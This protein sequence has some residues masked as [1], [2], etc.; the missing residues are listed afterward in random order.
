MGKFNHPKF[1]RFFCANLGF[2]TPNFIKILGE[3]SGICRE[4]VKR[5]DTIVESCNVTKIIEIMCMYVYTHTYI[6]I[7]YVYIYSHTCVYI[8]INIYFSASY[9]DF[10]WSILM[11]MFALQ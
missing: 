9:C 3:G 1:A 5:V 2:D 8:Y 11:I 7:L 6:Y 4:P 10:A